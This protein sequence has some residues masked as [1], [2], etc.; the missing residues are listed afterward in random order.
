[1]TVRQ[2]QAADSSTPIF[3]MP[4]VFAF[5]GTHGEHK[6][7][8]VRNNLPE[9]NFEVLLGFEPQWVDF[10]PDDLIDKTLRFEQPDTALIAEAEKDPSMMS[11]LWAVQQ[12]SANRQSNHV[13]DVAALIR[14]LNHESFYGVRASAA[15]S[16]GI[17]GTEPAKSALLA[18]LSQ[19]E[20]RVRMAVV[21]ALGHFA[22]DP[23]VFR[24]LIDALQHDTSYAVAA[25][26]AQVLGNSGM[27]HVFE[28]LQAAV[29]ASP[30]VHLMQAVLEALAATGDPRVLPALLAKAQPGEPERVR[31][32]ALAAL[33][34]LTPQKEQNQ[35]VAMQVGIALE[36][37]F[38][39]VQQAGV[40]L[41][42]HLKL[43][44][45]CPQIQD[46]ARKAPISD[47]QHAA[48]RVLRQLH[49]PGPG[50]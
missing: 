23:E 25:A 21:Q 39:P 22:H 48:E 5:Y 4:I 17:L 34:R 26:A 18:A 1:L 42:G 8:Q 9:Q 28:A 20:S 6:R 27:P 49:C 43:T 32:S 44:Q 46:I 7:V 38:A 11:R 15:K 50:Q 45:F 40:S 41:A 19:P 3:D 10:D 30:E 33:A 2:T 24:A 12:L 47:Y 35:E 29:I 14:V 16:L 31:L 13:Q 36:D 37:P